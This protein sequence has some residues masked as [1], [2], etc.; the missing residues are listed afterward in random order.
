MKYICMVYLINR[1]CILRKEFLRKKM[2]L[3]N[4]LIFNVDIVVLVKLKLLFKVGSGILCV[5][6]GLKLWL[7]FGI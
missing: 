1:F 6:V 5:G 7:L 3:Y 2:V 4:I